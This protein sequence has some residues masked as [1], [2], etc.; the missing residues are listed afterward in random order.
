[1]SPILQQKWLSSI[2]QAY[3]KSHNISACLQTLV[4]HPLW[5]M[6]VFKAPEIWSQGTHCLC[7]QGFTCHGR[8]QRPR[9]A[10]TDIIQGVLMAEE[11]L[12]ENLLLLLLLYNL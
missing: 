9:Q 10:N 1:M 4:E 6:E 11:K 5:P 7:L 3:V 2:S 12:G 8:G